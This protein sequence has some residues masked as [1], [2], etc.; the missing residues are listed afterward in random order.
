MSDSIDI[1]KIKLDFEEGKLPE[2][3]K[4]SDFIIN[5][6]NEDTLISMRYYGLGMKFVVIMYL[7]LSIIYIAFVFNTIRKPSMIKFILIIILPI[8]AI[9]NT[10]RTYENFKKKINP[11]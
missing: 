6:L 3:N 10:Y 2:K 9:G 11:I 8:A 1:N 5:K 4:I 7:L